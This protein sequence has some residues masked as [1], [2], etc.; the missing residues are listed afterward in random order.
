ME[1]EKWRHLLKN[2]QDTRDIMHRTMMPQSPS[3]QAPW[4]L[5]VL[6][7]PLPLLKTLQNPLLELPSDTPSYFPE[8]HQSSEMPSLSNVILVLGKARSGR[9]PILAVGD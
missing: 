7:V 1:Y 6:I 5:T 4:D 8:S 3:K 9:A 2:V